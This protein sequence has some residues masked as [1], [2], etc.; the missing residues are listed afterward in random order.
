MTMA[1]D[2]APV[3]LVVDDDP[4]LRDLFAMLLGDEFCARVVGT[5]DPAEALRLARGLRPTL[6]L[7]DLVRTGRGPAFCAALRA[8]PATRDIP[9]LVVTAAS[10]ACPDGA[11]LAARCDAWIAKPFDLDGLFDAIRRYLPPGAPCAGNSRSYSAR[12]SR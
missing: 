2:N 6:V 3:V 10:P 12:M 1:V 9:V 8:E 7:M 4:D 11:K 5:G